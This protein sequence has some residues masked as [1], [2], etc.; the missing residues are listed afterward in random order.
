LTVC[1]AGHPPPLIVRADGTIERAG[2]P[3]TIL[4]VLA[5]LSLTDV[6]VDLEEGDAIV[7]FTDG[8]T[9]ERRGSDAAGEAALERVLRGLRGA[10]AAEIGNAL[11]RMIT[12]PRSEPPRDDAAILVAR[13]IPAVPDPE[14]S[15]S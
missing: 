7:L 13:V 8:V 1:L 6:T 11:D 14:G 9:D 10:S 2:R 15:D 4:G 5:D 12:D 3:G